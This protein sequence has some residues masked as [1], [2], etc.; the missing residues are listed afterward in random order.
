MLAYCALL[1]SE[2]ARAT[3]D[4]ALSNSYCMQNMTHNT[5]PI[6]HVRFAVH[7]PSPLSGGF[8]PSG[9]KP[10]LNPH[11]RNPIWKVSIVSTGLRGLRA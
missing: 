10:P 3:S 8:N 5:A 11:S 2:L 7:S 6:E 1:L 4:S 9:L